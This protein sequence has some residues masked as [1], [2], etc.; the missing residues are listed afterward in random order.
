MEV[1]GPLD[2]RSPSVIPPVPETLISPPVIPSTASLSSPPV[3]HGPGPLGSPHGPALTP[4][5]RGGRLG[6]PPP[7]HTPTTL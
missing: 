6:S 1:E 7:T 3:I 2:M 4:A 5:G